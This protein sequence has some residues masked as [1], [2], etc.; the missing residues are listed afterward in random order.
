MIAILL[1]SAIRLIR[2]QKTLSTLKILGLAVGMAT[3]LIT[4]LFTLHELSFDQQH[5]DYQN[6]FRYVHRVKSDDELQSFAFT[7]ATTGPALK[8]RYREVLS[9]TRIFSSVVSLKRK[10]ADIGFVEKKFAFADPNF[11]ETFSFPLRQGGA[12]QVLSEPYAVLLTPES[13]TK[14]FGDEDPMGQSILLNGQIELVVKGVFRENFTRSHINFDFVSSFAALEVIKNNP[15]VSRQIPAALNLEHKGFSAFYTYLKLGS[16][17]DAPSLI[18]KFP[19]FIEEF[20]GEGRSERLKPTLQ[21]IETIHLESDMLYEIGKNGSIQIVLIYIII[22]A[23][24]LFAAVINYVNISTA[25]FIMRSR[26]V[27]LKKILGIPR[28]LL[29]LSH[30]AETMVLCLGA[31]MLGCLLAILLMPG[32]N[33]V[34][35]TRISFFTMDTVAMVALIYLFTVIVSG[36]LPAIQI[37]RME[38]LTAFKGSFDNRSTSLRLRNALVFTQLLVSVVLL[39]SSMLIFQQIDFLLQKDTGFDSDQIAIVNAAGLSI[40]DRTALKTKLAADQNIISTAM[41]STPPGEPLFTFGVNLPGS[42]G[43]EDRRLTFFQMFVDADFLTTMGIP[44]KEGRFFSESQAADSLHSFVINEAGA[45]AIGGNAMAQSVETPNIYTGTRA[46]KNAVGIIHD[47]HFNSFHTAVEPLLLE[48]SPS[49]ARYLLVRFN[50]AHA[51]EVVR[52]IELTWKESV[53][54]LPLNF[55]FQDDGFAK[56]Y[57]TE[58]R[59]KKIVAVVTLLVVCLTS[60]GI[61]GTSLFTLQQR[62]KEIAIRKFLGSAA[63]NLF[64]L[65]F[66]PTLLM[67]TA[68]TLAGAPLAMWIGNKWLMNYPYHTSFSPLLPLIAFALVLL[69]MFVTLVF[70]LFRILDIQPAKV[71]RQVS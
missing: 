44:L 14:Y 36:L 51:K 17:A 61:F 35:E 48:F 42:A 3:F 46:V 70:Y 60:L 24:I 26:S 22:G 54:M 28:A 56:F 66:R 65:L 34:M 19:A 67:L 62:T 47:F 71:L 1:T 9:F 15:V 18:E 7:S 30:F 27:G 12:H 58:Q 40:G 13:A 11:L 64:A 16:P 6:I 37:I 10:D 39:I 32:F 50:P 38:T 55:Y 68:A 63:L 57:A 49:N 23:L 41:C 21:S 33:T 43:D 8:E 59:A 29:L 20:R 69:V 5:P 52:V 45:K 2:K 4:A 25:E 31:V 53:P